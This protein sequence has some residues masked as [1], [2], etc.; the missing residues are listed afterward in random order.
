MKKVLA[1]LLIGVI[2]A[3]SAACGR[4]E[5]NK[6]SQSASS[7]VKTLKISYYTRELGGDWMKKIA[8]GFQKEN[9]GLKIKLIPDD[10]INENILKT[11]NA[12]SG[13]PDVALL[14]QT[15]WQYFMGKGWLC[16]L[17]AVYSSVEDG[18]KIIDKLQPGARD[19][20]KYKSSYYVL[21]WTSRVTGFIYNEK[22]FSDKV[23]AVPATL[24]ELNALL[25]KMQADGVTPF[26]WAGKAPDLWDNVVMGWWA[27]YEGSLGVKT[28]LTM[29]TPE[30]YRQPG[31]LI[32][33]QE[34]E[35][36][37]SDSANCLEGSENFSEQQMAAAFFK[38]RAAMIPE[39]SDFN[40]EYKSLIPPDFEMGMMPLPA[41]DGAKGANMNNAGPENFFCVPQASDE[42]GE[43]IK[44]LRYLYTDDVMSQFRSATGVPQPT[45]GLYDGDDTFAQSVFNIWK[46]SDNVYLYSQSPI[47]YG[48]L[49]DWPYSGKPYLQIFSGTETAQSVFDKNYNA[50]QQAF[51]NSGYRSSSMSSGVTVR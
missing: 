32:A 50:A 11:F 31:R 8:A 19:F 36:I 17:N 4:G 42:Q 10:N 41:P 21:P 20:G 1:L 34:F 15:N 46:S 28:Y 23:Y 6:N 37:I 16:R 25:Q 27:Q 26:A 47:Y 43:A 38:G 2:L 9:P 48:T 7:G 44:F 14:R 40:A 18:R 22:I 45:N 13:L 30:V 33:L 24:A 39:T 29:Q 49:H 5:T 35:S 3:F 12:G 51:I